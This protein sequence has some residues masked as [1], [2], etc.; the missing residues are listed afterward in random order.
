MADDRDFALKIFDSIINKKQSFYPE[1]YAE[2]N[3]A[4]VRMLL[5]TALRHLN[6]LEQVISR[7]SSQK[8]PKPVIKNAL[9]L[10]ATEILYM[11]SPDYAVINSY[12][13]IIKKQTDKF[14]AGFVN[15]ILRNISRNKTELQKNDKNPFFSPDFRKILRHDYSDNTIDLIE[16]SCLGEPSLDITVNNP[17]SAV[18]AMGT[19]LPL[20][21]LRLNNKGK[22]ENLPDYTKGFWWVQDFSS[23]LPVKMLDNIKGKKVLDLCAAPGGKTAQLLA[24]GAKATA[25]DISKERLQ[26]LQ[27]N[28][29]RL[30]LQA[31]KIIC[32]DALEY[33]SKTTEKFDIILLDAPCSA[34]GTL[35]RHP[36]VA[37]IKTSA[38]IDSQCLLQ[39]K[40][41]N[42]V[43][44]A[45][46]QGGYLM[47]CTC[48][49]CHKE[50]ELQINNFLSSHPE[51]KI[52]NLSSKLPD[53]LKILA[54]SQ[55]FIRVL[56]HYMQTYGYADGFFAACL[57][58]LQ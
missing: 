55:G 32:A 36:E 39:Q 4:F 30:N 9:L 11:D 53:E 7:L 27:K 3:S 47:Y 51:F 41:L 19:F 29:K 6:H 23:A 26:T 10:G 15:A 38:D 58:L 24:N 14:K 33:L 21:T 40:L 13:N 45:L 52:I 49:L 34:T 1:H 28:L 57:Q 31:D 8:K 18:C 16:Q 25:L 42:L 48:S 17:S 5:M 35:R 43:P 46:N 2:N 20:G 56:P 22:I 50:G 12:V 37:H 54:D 44:N